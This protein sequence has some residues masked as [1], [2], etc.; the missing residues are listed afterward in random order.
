MPAAVCPAAIFTSRA[1]AA[2]NVPTVARVWAGVK[3]CFYCIRRGPSRAPP[4]LDSHFPPSHNAPAYV[5]LQGGKPDPTSPPSKSPLSTPG[6][7]PEGGSLPTAASAPAAANGGTGG[8]PGGSPAGAEADAGTLSKSPLDS[9]D[10]PM[11]LGKATGAGAAGAGGV[12]PG[13]LE[14]EPEFAADLRQ[15]WRAWGS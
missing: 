15:A 3:L 4:P 9:P 6:L 5:I 11:L 13:G 14:L 10:G 8:K 7:G 1:P 2:C 12:P